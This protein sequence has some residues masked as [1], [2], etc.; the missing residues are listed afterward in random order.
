M[1]EDNPTHEVE[2]N[3]FYLH[4]HDA[5]KLVEW[6]E[7][8]DSKLKS[9]YARHAVLAVVFASEALANRL[10][11]R[12]PLS[13]VAAGGVEK[14]GIREKWSLIPF[15]MTGKPETREWFDT[16]RE[17]FQSFGEL[18]KIRNWLAHPKSGEY[19]AAIHDERATIRLLEDFDSDLETGRSIPWIETLKGDA[20]K[21][22]EIPLNPFEWTGQHARSAIKA[23]DSVVAEL[24]KAIGNLLTDDWLWEIDLKSKVDGTVSKI[25]VDSLWGGYTPNA[26]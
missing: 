17:P 20:W 7:A 6:A 22:T 21:Q 1:A 23:L 2:V 26:D 13:K 9:L 14:L 4:Y 11:S 8:E 3:F 24:K 10:L 18:V 15:L 16:S 19:V 5:E 12:L 25:T